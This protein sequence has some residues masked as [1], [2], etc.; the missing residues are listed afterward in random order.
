MWYSVIFF[1]MLVGC[2]MLKVL[3]SSQY[4][5][6]HAFITLIPLIA[7]IVARAKPQREWNWR[8]EL[9]AFPLSV[10]TL[11]WCH[12]M[13]CV[14]GAEGGA[15]VLAQLKAKARNKVADAIQILTASYSILQHVTEFY[16]CHRVTVC[17][18]RSSKLSI[19][20][21]EW[22]TYY[23]KT[24]VSLPFSYSTFFLHRS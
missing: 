16:S 4:L 10:L 14:Q 6:M 9:I 13:P 11:P 19:Q 22:K 15:S 3:C 1:C 12:D 23:M 7:V 21:V 5:T 18:L 17:R 2:S 24:R 20:T 8:P